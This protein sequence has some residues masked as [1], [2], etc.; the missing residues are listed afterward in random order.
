VAKL[1]SASG[2]TKQRERAEIEGKIAKSQNKYENRCRQLKI[3]KGHG[4]SLRDRLVEKRRSYLSGGELKLR[5]QKGGMN[6]KDTINGPD[7]RGKTDQKRG[8]IERKPARYN[9]KYLYYPDTHYKKDAKHE[10]VSR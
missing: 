2:N 9:I 4:M 5:I 8:T 6:G 3:G 1:L 7:S 10:G